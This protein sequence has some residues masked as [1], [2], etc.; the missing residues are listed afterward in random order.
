M[1]QPLTPHAR[2]HRLTPVAAL[3]ASGAFALLLAPTAHA[4]SQAPAQPAAAA[5]AEPADALLVAEAAC[6]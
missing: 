5:K 1:T 2:E 6:L 4:Q 3:V